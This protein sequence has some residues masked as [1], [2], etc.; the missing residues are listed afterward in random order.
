MVS[1]FNLSCRQSNRLQVCRTIMSAHCFGCKAGL[2]V[3]CSHIASVLFHLE[4]TTR[5]HDKLART[6]VKC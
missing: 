6:Q 4:A 3:S 2:A 5:I 1:G